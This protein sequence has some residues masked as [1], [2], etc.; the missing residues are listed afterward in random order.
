MTKIYKRLLQREML[1]FR[2]K[3]L[4]SLFFLSGYFFSL[5]AQTFP[6]EIDLL[7]KGKKITIT[8]KVSVNKPLDPR[9]ALTVT[10]QISITG[11][12]TGPI[13]SDDPDTPNP[14]DPTLS[15]VLG[16]SI[17]GITADVPVCGGNNNYSVNITVNSDGAPLTG[18]L[19]IEAGG[20][21]F[22]APV[23]PD[24]NKQ[25]IAILL[26]ANGQMIDVKAFY[27][28]LPECILIVPSLFT[29]PAG[30]GIIGNRVWED[31]NGDGIQN[32]GPNGI[33]NVTVVLLDCS[34]QPIT[35]TLTNASGL[36]QFT[37]LPAGQYKLR[38]NFTSAAPA[39][40]NA[41]TTLKDATSDALDSDIEVVTKETPCF[42]LEAGQQ[43]SDWDAGVYVPAQIGNLAWVDRNRNNFFDGGDTPLAG[44]PVTLYK[45]S[46][47]LATMPLAMQNTNANGLYLFSGL[48]P[49]IYKVKFGFPTTS[50]YERVIPNIGTDALDSDADANGFTNCYT[51]QSQ[52]QELSVDGG[53]TFCPPSTSLSC[54]GSVNI[55]MGE[56]CQVVVTPDMLLT[57]AP[58]C[59]STY[60]VRIRD[61]RG[62]NIGNTLTSA[63]VGQTLL[64][65]VI[66]KQTNATCSS[67]ITIF[68]QRKPVVTC[69]PN[70]NKAG[71]AQQVQLIN[72]TLS[73]LNSAAN[74]SSISCYQPIVNPGGGNHFYEYYSFT[75][76]QEDVYTFEL[77]T[78]FGDGAALLFDGNKQ[79][80]S[81]FC[82][83][84]IAQSYTSFTSG[85]FFTNLNPIIRITSRL[86]P[87]QIYTLATT[88]R[89][90]GATGA[91]FWAAY[92]DGNGLITGIPAIQ[93]QAQYDLICTDISQILNKPQSLTFVGSPIV[94]DNCTH[95]VTD[96]TFV[97]QLSEGSSCTGD[98]ITRTF[99]V[100]DA[101][102]N[103]AQCSQVISVRKPTFAD[104][105]YPQLTFFL[106]CSDEFTVD[107]NGNPHP[108]VTGYPLVKTAFGNYNLATS[109]CN[110]SATYIDKPR[111]VGCS[112]TYN[113]IREWTIQDI[114][115]IGSLL[116]F[117]QII[118]VGDSVEPTV[119]CPTVD[120]NNDGTLDTLVFSTSSFACS[121]TFNAPTPLI[122][123]N[124]SS[125][126]FTVEVLSDTLVPIL[127]QFG[128]IIDY[129]EQV[130][131]RA[132]A[133]STGSLQVSNIPIGTHRFRYTVT[134]ACGNE[135]IIE[136][137][138]KVEDQVAPAVVCKN[139]LVVSL[140]GTGEARVLATDID[141]GSRDNCAIDSILVRRRYTKDPL[142]CQP[143]TPYFS[144]WNT[145]VDIACCDADSLV[146]VELRVSDK[147][148]NSNTCVVN[149]QVNDMIRP[150]C[151]APPPISVPCTSLPKEFNPMDT[152]QLRTLFG[153]ATPTDNCIASWEELEPVVNLSE[154][155]VGTITRRFRTIDRVG[156]VSVNTCQQLITITKVNHYTIKFPKDTDTECG[157]PF[158][159]TLQFDA[160]GCD[161][162][163][164]GFTEDQFSAIGDEC[165]RIFRTYRV[166]N[167]CEYDGSSPPVVIGRDEDCDNKA[168]DED[169]WVIR[170]PNNTYVDRNNSE[171]DNIP[172]VNQRGCTPTNPKGYWRTASS[173]GY[174][175]YTQVIRV[176]D[177]TPPDVL[178]TPPTPFCST[179]DNCNTQL[180]V[181]FVVV[182]S[183]TPNSLD[184]Q[185]AIDINNDGISDGSLANYSGN[186]VG[187]YP[188][189][190]IRGTFP[191]GKHGFAITLRDGCD[192]TSIKKILFEVVDCKAPVPICLASKTVNL[193][194]VK[195]LMDVDGDGDQDPG[196]ITVKASELLN[197]MV[198]ECSGPVRYSLNKMGEIP[199]IN[200]DSVIFTCGDI[201]TS[202]VVEVYAWDSAANP[203]ALQP[204]G[205]VGGPNYSFCAMTINI[206][207]EELLAC[208][209]PNK[210]LVTGIIKT[211]DGK[212]LE[213]AQ[214]SLSGQASGLTN[215]LFD[216]S[217][218]FTL[219][220]EGY[221]YTITPYMD[222]LH[223]NGVN[224]V[225]LII[226]TKHIL[227]VQ[228]LDS[229]YKMI[230]ADVNNSKSISIL[231]I[232]QMRKIILGIDLEFPATTS[233]RFVRASYIFPV[234]TNPWFEEFP[235][236][237]SVNDLF[238]TLSNANFIAI[239]TGDV[240]LNATTVEQAFSTEPR[241]RAGGFAF[242]V[243]DRDI[244]AGE[245][246]KVD[247]AADLSTIQGY[248]WTLD[249]DQQHLEFIDIEYG[250]AQAENF[251]LH[252]V[253]QGHITSSWHEVKQINSTDDSQIR[254]FS[255]VF[256]A[257]ANG[258]LSNL[259]KISSRYTSAEAYDTQ[260]E[261]KD[262][263]IDFGNGKIHNPVFELY[264]N[265]PNPFSYS[266]SI[267]F[268]LPESTK[269]SL[270]IYDAGG[271]LLKT[272]E[273]DF[274]KGYHQ[275]SIDRAALSG[276]GV[277]YYT[278]ES[279]KYTAT[280][281][282]I[283]LN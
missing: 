65:L 48:A 173:L 214:V 230:A 52:K 264:Q 281:K 59:L 87:G 99:T 70:T 130:F 17:I 201:G 45:C 128:F 88:S 12:N 193:R 169:I 155:L 82:E 271:R 29:A 220:E 185:I 106:E 113:F 222:T 24:T 135:T 259:I 35:Q 252:A 105:I 247:F 22:Q 162:I 1:Y 27:S 265:I 237:I 208:V 150:F 115:N 18:N 233:W 231:D 241:G 79:V 15:S 243:E 149:V 210:G 188:N 266:T 116:K 90:P 194:P 216:G 6:V 203:Y 277:L 74:L 85:I 157:V 118:R 19:V 184:I 91:Y 119:S 158:A 151:I 181:P 141:A 174:W 37:E 239:K 112:E 152:A 44:V 168:G 280:R 197:G 117:N 258:K 224:T 145:F 245:T 107:V 39:F 187:I 202:V 92:S 253:T 28:D 257:R 273:G 248:Q 33:A 121:A 8:Y 167:W 207:D 235:E 51:V 209:P 14:N 30:C 71:Y 171:T 138:F 60:E 186:L 274:I 200:K 50:V 108:M 61:S 139:S 143:V 180:A 165:Y 122:A 120:Y 109:Y 36:Y 81:S 262:V 31:L 164:I 179:N 218:S 54:R 97:D 32:D 67:N 46:D 225:D 267:G 282:M 41:V 175:Q 58:P 2:P 126:T 170:R 161:Q 16:C 276:S 177:T 176:F 213:K 192:N 133:Q 240:N 62:M 198:T 228:Y 229:P 136:C 132:T 83:D 94:T 53:Y 104:I 153:V 140:G 10:D 13:L 80:G 227:G 154:C 251:G 103:F 226:I 100:R 279:L 93:T 244:R 147:A 89:A 196:A 215:T 72:S 57:T 172:A 9:I 191:K 254:M 156:N 190:E 40:A 129:E 125:S 142:T 75:V 137:P 178:F 263:A 217:Y 146:T 102:G 134:D 131:V 55:N 127:D 144:E 148:G 20:Q 206:S 261:K 77:S 23:D 236:V 221:D 270:N 73:V 114:C 232:I 189:Y 275:V 11:E 101:A 238:G 283:L 124:C 38:F 4:L 64:A 278:L 219:L 255:L 78:Q 84:L 205:T 96:I 98:V 95:P 183:C 49:G 68:D 195:P 5:Q 268:Y 66:D 249:F 159:D 26:P 163:S 111:A 34:N 76:T 223:R 21:T 86:R 199:N 269:V 246:Y 272:I 43:N 250:L 212:P 256:V 204:N 211:E 56:D 110:I 25:T 242:Y 7:P 47:S 63:H 69:P 182:E 123:D 260:Y 3:F 166:I 160:L 234:Q 42:V